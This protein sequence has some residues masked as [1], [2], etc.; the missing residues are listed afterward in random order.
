M[1]KQLKKHFDLDVA[2]KKR[3]NMPEP[4]TSTQT[5][6]PPTGT[7]PTP[8]ENGDNKG[9]QPDSTVTTPKPDETT[10]P[11]HRFD[12]VN[13]E[14]KEMREWRQEQEKKAKELDEQNLIKK[15]E[16][17][18]LA[19][20]REEEANKYKSELQTERVNNKIAAEAAKLGITD[21]EA[22]TML[23][24]RG[25]IKFDEN[26]VPQGIAE[27]VQALIEARPYLKSGVPQPTVGAGTTPAQGAAGQARFKLSQVQDSTF[28]RANE[29]EIMEAYK[30]GLIEDDVNHR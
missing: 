29:K 21:I 9:T 12:E 23:I 10:I 26:G 7:V 15:G 13:K 3:R 6:T 25:Q 16:F 4:I 22:A 11:K 24:D 18:K 30:L 2:R 5:T 1:R 20:Q 17:E 14:L 19:Q 8:T 27:A 28:Y